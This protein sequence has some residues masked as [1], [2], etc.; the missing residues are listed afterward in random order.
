MAA[1]LAGELAEA[2]DL[3]G[4]QLVSKSHGVANGCDELAEIVDELAADAADLVDEIAEELAEAVATE[5]KPRRQRTQRKAVPLAVV[6]NTIAAMKASGEEVTG[7]TLAERLGCS[8]RSG[9]RYLGE[10]RAA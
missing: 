8:E 6:K 9:Y 3:A 7:P 4:R 10:V 5:P 2:L 1:S